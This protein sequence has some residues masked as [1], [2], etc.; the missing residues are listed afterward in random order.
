MQKKISVCFLSAWVLGKKDDEKLPVARFIDAVKTVFVCKVLY[1][2]PTDCELLVQAG[3]SSD[4]QI[5]KRIRALLEEI[6]ETD[7]LRFVRACEVADY[8]EKDALPTFPLDEEA[9]EAADG[10]LLETVMEK[11]RALVG[12]EEFK[13]LAEEYVKIAPGLLKYHTQEALTHQAYLFAIN[14]GDGLSTY[15][16]LFAELFAALQLFT[17]HE[18][19]PIA[20]LK[21]PLPSPKDLGDPFS[22]VFSAL[23]RNGAKGGKIVSI[24]ISEWM[25][26]INDKAFREFLSQL[27]DQ[28]GENIIVFRV[29]FLDKKI[30][31]GLKRGLADMLFIREVSFAPFDRDE[32]AQC[33]R[34]FLNQLGFSIEEAALD[35]FHARIIEE[36]NDGRFYGINTVKKVI[37]EMIYKKQLDNALNGVDDT[38]VKKSEILSLSALY[39][40]HQK[41][42]DELLNEL[43]GVD[44]IRARVDEIVCQ[45]EAGVKFP[46]LGSPCIHMRFVGNPGT[47][48]TTVARVIGKI[49]KE[50]GILRN[51]HFF[52][53]SGR[54]FC[55]QYVGETAPKTAAMCRDAYGSVLFIDEAYS[56]YRENIAGS[57][58]Y[59][60]EAIDTMIAEMEN[61]RSDLVI[62]MAGYPDE[63][64]TLMKANAGLESRMPYVIEFPNYTREQLY[65]IFMQMVQKTFTY[66][67]GFDEAVKEYFDSLPEE[68]I[69]SKE[70][71]NARFVR[72][73]FE[74][75]WGKAMLRAQLN[76]EDPSVLTKQDF[77]LASAEKEFKKIMVK[78]NRSLGFI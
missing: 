26:K 57:L 5:K 36:K 2:S 46:K 24:D 76:K 49:L 52:E 69:S 8:Q 16:N 75:T 51:G 35:V 72:N 60:R 34:N 63:M 32:L 14:D 21:V 65:E 73:L 56:L 38:F 31:D 12:A 45:I 68:W 66:L 11:I 44:G 29:P 37:R 58:D 39:S 4:D 20:E 19:K 22:P 33:A 77:L 61:H 54:D 28:M 23:R 48:K 25:T 18:R 43:V 10:N 40:D 17:F 9:E 47:G 59:G 41:T 67:E 30:L 27:D 64:A 71:S 50:K 42:A 55:G 62:I 74:R 1:S 13:A 6:F 53:Y 15:L 3:D 78:P 70:F 7:D